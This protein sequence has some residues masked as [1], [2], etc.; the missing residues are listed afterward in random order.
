MGRRLC[1]DAVREQFVAAVLAGGS[2]NSVAGSL[3]VPRGTARRWW[4]AAAMDVPL[5]KGARGG[6]VEPLPSPHERAG[7]Y[8]SAE[9]RA[10]IQ[11]G[12]SWR[13]SLAQIGALIGRDKSVISREL[14]RNRGGDGV[15]RA[16]LA[17]RAARVRRRRPKPFKLRVNPEL[18]A[19]V[20]GWMDQGWSPGL[21]AHALAADAGTDQTWRVSHETIYQALYVQSRGQLRA[22]LARSLSTRRTKRK[23]HGSIDRRGRSLYEHAFKISERPPEVHDRA[24]PGHWEGDLIMGTGNRSAIGTLVERASRFVILLHL[25]GRHTSDEVAAA[26]IR[27]MRALPD[28]LRRSITWDRGS[29]MAAYE[30]IQLKLNTT[31]YFADPHAPW[32]RGSNEN[33]NRLLRFWFEKGTDLAPW[34]ADKIQHVQDSLNQRPR[35]TLGY[36]TPAQAF[37]DFLTTTVATTT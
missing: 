34:T 27:Q 33:T 9:D 29:E 32:Q 35:P 21:I 3:G 6:V 25:P 14:R 7:R 24:V 22:D 4:D 1:A 16:R 17:D 31:V 13:L 8:L 23:P 2:V 19:Q 28:H 36:R 18:C 11:V 10:V 26:M 20:E 37:N 5:R 12:V 30:H 15:Y